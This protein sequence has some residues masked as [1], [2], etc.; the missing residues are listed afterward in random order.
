M[1]NINLTP[2][3][4]LRESL[5]ILH[6]KLNFC[7]NIITEYDD[8]FA[9][10]GGKIGASMRIRQPIQYATSTAATMPT[11]TGA[12]SIG[13][14]T[15]LTIDTQRYVP[16]RFTTKELT[17]DIED[18]SSRHVEPA[19]AKLAA[20][21]EADV[22]SKACKGT[23]GQLCATVGNVAFADVMSGRK[24]L[25][26]NLAPP[27]GRIALMDTQGNVDLVTDNK[28]LFNDNSQISKQYKEG[29]MGRFGQFDFYENTL[30]PKH[31][32]GTAVATYKVNGAS[33]EKTISASDSDPMNGV[34]AI[35][36]GT[37]DIVAGEI[38]T[39]EGCN[40]V[41][42]ETKEDTGV[43]KR[44]VVTAALSAAGNLSISPAIIKSGPHQNVSAYPTDGG[45]IT[46]IG[47]AGTTYNQSL[48]FQKGF[49]AL[50]TAD[51]VMPNGVDMASRQNYDGISLRLIRDYDISKDRIYTRI[52]CLYGSKVLRPD[53]AYRL[54][55]T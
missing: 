13:V 47:V 46:T 16:M 52:D 2:D 49:M 29:A 26:D 30:I 1:A 33:Q 41:H 34:I 23:A 11:G 15:T 18:F 51:L 12:D 28:A 55:H 36:T 22:L 39:I 5:R 37:K 4:I 50:G 48:L 17:L 14:S 38:V 6:Q 54:L 21:I 27:D 7:T 53:L 42:P 3:A 10:E 44:F 9:S 45:D 25:Q 40:A 8:S 43:L 32:A 35:D 20:K 31:T 19:M 24:S